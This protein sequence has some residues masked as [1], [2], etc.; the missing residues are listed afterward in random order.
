MSKRDDWIEL[1]DMLTPQAQEEIRAK[2]LKIL[3]FEKADIR[4]T[5]F[6]PKR[7]WGVEVKTYHPDEVNVV[8]DKTGEVI[9]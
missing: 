1:Q 5:H 7:I 9:A 3:R 8:D 6:T 2:K 4:I